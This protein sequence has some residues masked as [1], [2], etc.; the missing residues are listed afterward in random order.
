MQ[1]SVN[2]KIAMTLLDIANS[3]VGTESASGYG[4]H[5][6]PTTLQYI[7]FSDYRHWSHSRSFM[8]IIIDWSITAALGQ[9]SVFSSRLMDSPGQSLI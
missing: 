5:K 8:N 2:H 9:H 4:F 6:L 3:A 1:C 7:A